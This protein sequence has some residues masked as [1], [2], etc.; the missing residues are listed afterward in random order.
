MWLFCLA[1][2]IAYCQEPNTNKWDHVLEE[3]ITPPGRKRTHGRRRVVIQI[4]QDK[5][6]HV[7]HGCKKEVV[8]QAIRGWAV[9]ERCRK[10]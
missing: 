7:G 4:L 2:L 8:G 10:S 6:P 9:G 5:V 3:V 1:H